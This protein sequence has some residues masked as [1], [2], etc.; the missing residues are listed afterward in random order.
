MQL[1]FMR[2]VMCKIFKVTL[3]KNDSQQLTCHII[4]VDFYNG[5]I[6]QL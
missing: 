4:S 5:F 1:N 2:F 3:H 6:L